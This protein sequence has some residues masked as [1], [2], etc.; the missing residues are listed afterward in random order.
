[1]IDYEKFIEEV[2]P[3]ATQHF[4]DE[5]IETNAEFRADSGIKAIIKRVLVGETCQWCEELAGVYEYGKHPSD[6]FRRHRN[7]DCIV[8]YITNKER[9]NV[10]TKATIKKAREERLDMAKEF[11]DFLKNE[12]AR[13]KA[14]LIEETEQYEENLEKQRR[15]RKVALRG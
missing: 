2:I 11:N 3:N 10:H 1:M 6:V 14:L 7:C 13:R 5:E 9:T 15:K 8:E 12:S 4:Y